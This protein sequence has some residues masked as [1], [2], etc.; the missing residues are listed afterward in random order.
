MQQQIKEAAR[1]LQI[2]LESE[3]ILIS[4]RQERQLIQ[5]QKEEI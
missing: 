2:K 5:K 3:G 4:I 1:K